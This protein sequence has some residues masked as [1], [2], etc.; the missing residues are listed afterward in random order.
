MNWLLMSLLSLGITL[1]AYTLFYNVFLKYRF[2]LLH[3][4]IGTSAVCFLYMHVFSI[5]TKEFQQYTALLVWLLWPAT[6]ALAVPLYTQLH[7]LRSLHWRVIVP[8][9]IGGTLAPVL[10][11]S[12]VALLDVDGQIKMTMLVKSI[13]TPLAMQT[14]ELIGGISS[15]AAVLVILTG[16]VVAVFGPTIAMLVKIDNQIAE[17]IAMGT[18]GHAIATARAASISEYCLALSSASLCINGL[19]TSLMLPILFK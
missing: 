19:V 4:I 15:L 5:S 18:V 1:I 12:C 17:G 7:L 9:L 8:I 13:T 10:S 14:A 2:A 11:W 16:I 3:P 6:V